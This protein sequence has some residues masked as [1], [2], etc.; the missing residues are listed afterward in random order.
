M[1][2]DTV[3]SAEFVTELTDGLDEGEGFDVAN[4]AADFDDDDVDAFGYLAGVGFDFVGDVGD[5][6]NCFAEVIAAPLAGDDAF[7]DAAA[8]EVACER[9]VWV[10]RS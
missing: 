2:E 10:K 5:D 7:V 6:L 8:G 1:D 4:G 9:W 3:V